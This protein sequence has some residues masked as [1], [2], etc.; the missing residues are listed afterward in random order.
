MS[1][2]K[3]EEKMETTT[4]KAQLRDSGTKGQLNAMRRGGSIPA[5]CYADKQEPL[6]V[7]LDEHEFNVRWIPGKKNSI[8]TLDVEGGKK[9]DVIVHEVQRDVISQKVT[10]VDFMFVDENKPVQVTVP[11]KLVG[12]PVGV[13]VEGGVMY[14][15]AYK[16]RI[17]C[18]PNAIPSGYEF[19][20][21]ALPANKT[22][23]VSDIA[24]GDAKLV[25]SPRK[26]LLRITKGRS[27]S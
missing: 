17:S 14:Q 4:L 27:E 23:Y 8:F 26:V 12:I 9:V 1:S 15:D 20:V 24:L 6:L 10:H 22:V 5:V 18:M 2:T 19:D 25:D 11:V 7:V 13:K 16:V 3:R 21:S